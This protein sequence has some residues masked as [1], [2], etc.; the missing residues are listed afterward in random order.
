M[1]YK[2]QL[3]MDDWTQLYDTAKLLNMAIDDMVIMNQPNGMDPI[4]LEE[5]LNLC[6]RQAGRIV[7]MIQGMEQVPDPKPASD[8]STASTESEEA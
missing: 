6:S 3:N 7:E 8:D 4:D 1:G 5:L 2:Q